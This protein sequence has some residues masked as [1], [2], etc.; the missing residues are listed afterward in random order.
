MGKSKRYF[1]QGKAAVFRRPCCIYYDYANNAWWLCSDAVRVSGR[2]PWGLF[3]ELEQIHRE[4]Q[5]GL[6]KAVPRLCVFVNNLNVFRSAVIDRYGEVK[7][8]GEKRTKDGVMRLQIQTPLF[9][10][11]NFSSVA[12]ISPQKAAQMFK[13]GTNADGMRLLLDEL[14]GGEPWAKLRWSL[15]YITKK[16]FY[17]PIKAELWEDMKR[18]EVLYRSLEHYK[19]MF[20]GSKAGFMRTFT[21]PEA[22]KAL[23]V[24]FCGVQAWDIKSAYPSVFVHDEYFPI[25]APVRVSRG[26]GSILNVRLNNAEWF[27]IVIRSTRQIQQLELFE[28][29]PDGKTH[30]Y[31]IEFYDWR[32][33]TELLCCPAK[34]IEAIL[35]N[36]DWDLYI[37]PD[38]GLL[39]DAFR[40]EI[41]AAYLNKDAI[42]DKASPRRFM[43]KTELDMLYGK[44]IQYR[45]FKTVQAVNRYLIGRGDNYLQP[46]HSMHAISAIRFRIMHAIMYAGAPA[47][48][49]DTDG[50]KLQGCCDDYFNQ[51][52]AIIADR[53]Y[54]SGFPACT[55]GM[56]DYEGIGRYIQLAPKSYFFE[57]VDAPA[58]YKH[59]GI[60]DEDFNAYCAGITGDLLEHFRQPRNIPISDAYLYA[61]DCHLYARTRSTFTL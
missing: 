48:N 40:G 44:A 28:G 11:R 37:S 49:W 42:T 9:I 61:P 38:T 46:A 3:D 51:Q 43:Y 36:S 55:I 59:S 13:A 2:S 58:Q 41:V 32:V 24:I 19:D 39:A 5:T 34:E 10:F 53:N 57:P 33:L 4:E 45:G 20:A 25:G 47:V 23:R 14:A 15:A 52:N 31:G 26:K 7:D 17:A 21:A 27:K 56:W 16:R 6:K 54:I 12:N 50:L 30:R 18:E 35:N 60:S 1:T 29:T 22:R 8:E